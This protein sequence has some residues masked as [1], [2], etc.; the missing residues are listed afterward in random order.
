MKKNYLILCTLLSC[1]LF[2]SANAQQ[3]KFG[4]EAGA[5]LSHYKNDTKAKQI[6]NMGVG[7]QLGGTVGYE[8]KRHWMLMSGFSFMQTQ[9][10]MELYPHSAPF[11]PDTEIK[12]S[13]LNIPIKVGY[14][15]HLNK[16][17]SLIPYIGIYNSLN[18]NAGKCDIKE[19]TEGNVNHHWKPMDGY[20]YV[21]QGA[22]IPYEATLD[23]FR[24]WNCGAV[25]GLK[26]VIKEHYTIS[27]QYY[28]SVT[29][30]QKQCNIRNFGYQL[31]IGYQF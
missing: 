21:L 12:M 29:K 13:H 11:F 4:I 28:E 15:L 6:G 25:G 31:S 8:F 22:K 14:N 30:M 9:S 10:R 2:L 24:S 1:F 20:S 19:A 26:V 17:I 3:V 18:F 7:F 23:A 16:G 27:V 5:N